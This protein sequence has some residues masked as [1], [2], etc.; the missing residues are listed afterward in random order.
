MKRKN[1]ITQEKTELKNLK[2]KKIMIIKAISL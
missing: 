2:G 1:K